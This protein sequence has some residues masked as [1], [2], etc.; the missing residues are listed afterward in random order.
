MRPSSCCVIL[1]SLNDTMFPCCTLCMDLEEQQRV[2]KL[3][4]A[5]F[6]RD[7]IHLPRQ[8]RQHVMS[9]QN[10]ITRYEREASW[11]HHDDKFIN[12]I[13]IGIVFILF[14]I[15]IY[16][17]IFYVHTYVLN[18]VVIIVNRISRSFMHA[19][20]FGDD[21]RRI[22]IIDLSCE[23]RYHVVSRSHFD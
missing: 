1:R 14:V 19:L 17:Y 12:M 20:S 2:A 4:C 7:G 6:E 9:L 21:L 13:L 5:E 23:P 15:Y 10:R 8:K 16:I 3:L 11:L 22:S 18:F